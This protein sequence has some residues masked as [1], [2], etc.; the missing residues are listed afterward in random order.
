MCRAHLSC[1]A[2]VMQAEAPQ[3]ENRMAPADVVRAAFGAFNRR[4]LDEGAVYLSPDV[5]WHLPES[6]LNPSVVRGVDALRGL[7]EA[8]FEAFSEVRRDPVEL[9]EDED[10]RVVGT[11]SARMRG[12]ASGIELEERAPYVFTVCRGRIARGEP[13]A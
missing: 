13:L 3:S 9:E 10:G 4:A 2:G 1:H 6:V 12:R 5:E 11:I 7:L 8:E